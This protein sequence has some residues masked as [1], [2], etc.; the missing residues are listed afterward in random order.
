MPLLYF[1]AND[2][3]QGRGATTLKLKTKSGYSRGGRDIGDVANLSNIS[4]APAS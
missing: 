3:A 4:F 2:H 1:A